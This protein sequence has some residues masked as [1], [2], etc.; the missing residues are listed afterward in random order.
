MERGFT[1]GS[2]VT[3]CYPRGGNGQ[4]DSVLSHRTLESFVN[5]LNLSG[6]N[7][8]YGIDRPVLDETNLK[9]VYLFNYWFDSPEDFRVAVI[10]GSARPETGGRGKLLVDVLVI[11]HIEQPSDN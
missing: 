8:R 10:E 9:G 1:N 4:S 5:E 3:P 11:D 2:R 6:F 7:A